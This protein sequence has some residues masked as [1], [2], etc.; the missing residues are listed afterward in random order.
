MSLLDLSGVKFNL[1]N[2]MQYFEKQGVEL[3]AENKS[4]LNTIFENC[5]TFNDEYNAAGPDGFISKSEISKFINMVSLVMPFAKAQLNNFVE[6]FNTDKKVESQTAPTAADATTSSEAVVEGD[7]KV[8]DL[9]YPKP[10]TATTDIRTN[11]DWS[12]EE[13]N[14][15]L[16]LMLDAP[17]YK[18][19]FKN[20]VLKGKAKAF[21]EAGKKYNIDPRALL[22]IVMCESTRGTSSVALNK[23][24]VGGLRGSKGYITFE[25]VDASIDKIAEI[26]SKRYNQGLTTL[27][28]I[29][30]S[31]KYCAKSAS[32][33]WIKEGNSYLSS[34]NKY[35]T[36]D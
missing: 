25:S 33:A 18:G 5:D 17:R 21:I 7:I 29:G 27:T 36:T 16:E 12:E 20:S 9:K 14:K 26:L 2:V 3:S 4:Q 11:Y 6:T 1:A 10:L 23:N 13:F 15:V 24:N 34:F 30:Q 19:K 32:A 22:A 31:G 35:Y 28:K 8:A